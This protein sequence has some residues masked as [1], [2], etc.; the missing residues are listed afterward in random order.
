MEKDKILSKME[1]AWV[2][3]KSYVLDETVVAIGSKNRRV[4][5]F[6]K[7]AVT[8]SLSALVNDALSL[9]CWK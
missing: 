5:I 3:P 4:E 8:R 6:F 1:K 9:F 7:E 2:L